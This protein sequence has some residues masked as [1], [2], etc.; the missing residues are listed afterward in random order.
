LIRWPGTNG[1]TVVLASETTRAAAAV[2]AQTAL[3]QGLPKVGLLVSAGYSSLHPG[4]YVVFSG[5]YATLA[6][7][8]AAASTAAKRYPSAYARQI[9]R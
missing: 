5:V 4:Y 2:K 3:D 9:T 1:Y 7:A 8:Q 6:E